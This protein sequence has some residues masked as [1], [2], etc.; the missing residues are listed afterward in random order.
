VISR[1]EAVPTF[2]IFAGVNKPIPIKGIFSKL[3]YRYASAVLKKQQKSYKEA[4]A[5][6]QLS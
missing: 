5:E 1:L 3:Y 6:S 2:D 4:G